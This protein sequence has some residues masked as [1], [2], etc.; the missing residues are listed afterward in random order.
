[1]E[2]KSPL[3]TAASCFDAVVLCDGDYPS[4][5]VALSILQNAQ[6]L[7]CCDGAG[8]HNILHGGTPDVIVGDGDSLPD[9][10]KKRYAD[11]VHLVDEQDDNDQTKATR[12][13]MKKG[14]KRI[15][16]VGCTGKREDH[17]LCNISLMMK[18]MRE[19]GLDVTMITDTG[20]FVP[21]SGIRRFESFVRQ[22]VSIFNFG[23]SRLSGKGLKWMP[24][25]YKELW[26]GG[27]NEALGDEVV[28]NGDGDYL[29]FFTFDA[30]VPKL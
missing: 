25:P 13:C 22:Q 5:P 11:L 3:V 14:M 29:M 6:F 19:W 10:F 26:Q 1:M 17:T 7:V 2:D 27:L 24:Y 20:Y 9:D 15:A 4:H 21:A 16:Y 28:M 18:Y 8:M 23:S 12:F 30:K